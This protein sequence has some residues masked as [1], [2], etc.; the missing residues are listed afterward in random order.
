MEAVQGRDLCW[1]EE[2]WMR[3]E[4][5]GE[6]TAPVEEEFWKEGRGQERKSQQGRKPLVIPEGSG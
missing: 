6:R 5:P 2:E 3:T 1:R 4:E